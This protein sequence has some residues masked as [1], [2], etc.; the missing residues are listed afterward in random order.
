[1]L[2]GIRPVTEKTIWAIEAMPGMKG[3]FDVEGVEAPAA[4]VPND[5]DWP[6]KTIAA[7]DVRALPRWSAHG[8]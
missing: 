5:S 2:S 4:P 3:W 8:T 1:M 6:F 7:A